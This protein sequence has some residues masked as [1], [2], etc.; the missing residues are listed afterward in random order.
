M[1]KGTGKRA[2]GGLKWLGR[3][4]GACPRN[5]VSF[6]T[7]R[8]WSISLHGTVYIGFKVDAEYEI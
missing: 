8:S 1:I 2:E 7:H 5:K 6:W 4:F 3:W